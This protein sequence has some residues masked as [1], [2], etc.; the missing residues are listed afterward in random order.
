M[1]TTKVVHLKGTWATMKNSLPADIK[2]AM[3]NWI[4]AFWQ[5]HAVVDKEPDAAVFDPY[6]AGAG[7][8]GPTGVQA[9][10]AVGSV[11]EKLF[12]SKR[13]KLV[14]FDMAD[15][16]KK[17]QLDQFFPLVLWPAS[18]AVRELAT[19]QKSKSF[20]CAEVKKYA[21]CDCW[22]VAHWFAFVCLQVL[23]G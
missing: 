2:G 11:L 12:D 15:K 5:K 7:P 13:N 14:A 9:E 16:M 18:T 1:E 20:V 19:Q 10:A 23:A 4:S 6:T 8:A 22:A 3:E 17:L 21:L